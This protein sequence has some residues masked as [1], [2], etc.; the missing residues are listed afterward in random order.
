M[1]ACCSISPSLSG[2]TTL[3][4]SQS[5]DHVWSRRG[6]CCYSRVASSDVSRCGS[7]IHKDNLPHKFRVQAAPTP[8]L[9]ST[10]GEGLA[11]E[12]ECVIARR[13]RKARFQVGCLLAWGG[14]YREAD[15]VS[16][17]RT[18]RCSL[19]G[20]VASRQALWN[21]GALWRPQVRHVHSHCKCQAT[22]ARL[23]PP[24]TGPLFRAGSPCTSWLLLEAHAFAVRKHARIRS[25]QVNS[26]KR[27][28]SSPRDEPPCR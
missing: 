24:S 21:S 10:L 26:F 8:Y 18:C 27:A 4:W 16:A 5:I 7:Q 11:E 9:V 1:L 22:A 19:L 28:V 14:G 25:I 13:A 3:C 6:C 2:F 20:A 17:S 15:C 23:R 12:N